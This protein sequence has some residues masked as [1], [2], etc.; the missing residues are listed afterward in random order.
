MLT[1][2]IITYIMVA[3][4]VAGAIDRII[5]NRFGLGEK[6]EKAFFTM[7]SLVLSMTGML[8]IAPVLAELLG[9]VMTPVFHVIGAD[10]AVFAGMFMGTDRGAAPLAE[11]LALDPRSGMFAGYV[12]SSMMGATVV[13]HIPVAMEIAGQDSSFISRGM[14]AG[15]ITFPIGCLAGG[16]ASGF[17]IG[18]ILND[19]AP[20]AVISAVL[21]LGML[22]FQQAMV[23]GFA[24][25]G[26]GIQ[27]LATFGLLLGI[28]Q[29]LVGFTPVEGITPIN[30]TFEI[31]GTVAVF[32]AGAFPL[33]HVLTTILRHPLRA[34]GEKIGI[35]EISAAGPLL[36]MVNSI[37]MLESMTEMD[38]RGKVINAAFCVTGAFMFGDFFGYVAA[39][40]AAMLV[41]MILAKLSAGAAS[42][43][44]AILMTRNSSAYAIK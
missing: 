9:P 20:V 10:P 27:T 24:W 30:E 17:P 40:N 33:M 31:V 2:Q 29:A 14:I 34:V 21:V 41:P 37:P 28:L 1:T 19:I 23:R 5:G 12:I 4:A 3:F 16:I 42:I 13:F 26:K 7:G 18:L 15:V 22:K 38:P 36:T 25:L 43:V 39:A 6:F 44:L 8:I 32:L 11:V 35:N